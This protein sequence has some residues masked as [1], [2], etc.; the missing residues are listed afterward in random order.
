VILQK[1][2]ALEADIRQDLDALE[3]MLGWWQNTDENYFP[4]HPPRVLGD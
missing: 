1:L 2:R 3:E 4:P